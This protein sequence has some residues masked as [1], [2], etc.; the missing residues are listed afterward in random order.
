MTAEKIGT[1]RHRTRIERRGRPVAGRRDVVCV[2][3]RKRAKD[4]CPL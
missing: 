1:Y 3:G 4:E 2:I